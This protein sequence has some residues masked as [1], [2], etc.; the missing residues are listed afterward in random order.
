MPALAAL[1]PQPM[2][3]EQLVDRFSQLPIRLQALQRMA[4]Q[5]GQ[6]GLN[7]QSDPPLQP[8]ELLLQLL[9]RGRRLV[10]FEPFCIHISAAAAAGSRGKSRGKG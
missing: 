8:I 7:R 4:T 2:A 1:H 3:V 5:R 10:E 9:Q 6:L